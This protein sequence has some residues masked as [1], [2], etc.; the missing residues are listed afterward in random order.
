MDVVLR[1][2]LKS[3]CIMSSNNS[4]FWSETAGIC[5]IVG[6][7]VGTIL[8]ALTLFLTWRQFRL[9]KGHNDLKTV[10]NNNVEQK[11]QRPKWKSRYS[12][13]AL[14]VLFFIGTVALAANISR[15][16]ALQ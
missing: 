4:D 10:N 7:I 8:T 14:M 1:I 6:L 11:Q 2:P 3:N 15:I 12:L 5:T 13:M 16:Q 9:L